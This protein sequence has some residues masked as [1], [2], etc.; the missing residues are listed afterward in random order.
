VTSRP[1]LRLDFFPAGQGDDLLDRVQIDRAASAAL[2]F[3]T[4]SLTGISSFL[5]ICPQ[6]TG[7]RWSSMNTA[8]TPSSSYSRTVRVTHLTSPNPSPASTRTGSCDT[9]MTWRMASCSS[10][11]WIRSMSGYAQRVPARANPPT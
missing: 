5:P 9:A 2:T 10:E 1:E 4:I 7:D 6:F 11:K 3:P 8:D